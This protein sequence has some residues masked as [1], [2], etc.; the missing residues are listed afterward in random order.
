MAV[1]LK[2]GMVLEVVADGYSS[3]L[4]IGD[5][6]HIARGVDEPDNGHGLTPPVLIMAPLIPIGGWLP[7]Y[8]TGLPEA[9]GEGIFRILGDCTMEELDQY[10]D[11]R[12]NQ[13]YDLQNKYKLFDG[14]L[15]LRR[16]ADRARLDETTLA[17]IREFS[18]LT[19]FQ[20]WTWFADHRNE[21]D[22]LA[23]EAVRKSYQRHQQAG[24]LFLNPET[25]RLI[26]C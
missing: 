7:I 23:Q 9:V 21:N 13:F 24:R 22:K 6:G 10:N 12:R 5:R 2:T 16:T 19:P 25:G 11:K 17:I 18:G 15:D 26:P 14:R 20:V 8:N 1:K 4:T 3:E